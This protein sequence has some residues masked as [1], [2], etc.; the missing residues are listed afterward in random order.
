M[1]AGAGED[2]VGLVD[3]FIEGRSGRGS[4]ACG[5][6][7]ECGHVELALPIYEAQVDLDFGRGGRNTDD[8]DAVDVDDSLALDVQVAHEVRRQ[9]GSLV[10][11]GVAEVDDLRQELPRLHVGAQLGA[12]VQ[13]LIDGV[14]VAFDPGLAEL[15]RPFGDDGGDE[16]AEGFV[17][18]GVIVGGVGRSDGIEVIFV[19]ETGAIERI[20]EVERYI[21]ADLSDE[22]GGLL[23]RLER[24]EDAGGVVDEVDDHWRGLLGGAVV[25]A[26]EP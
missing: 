19:V 1:N 14:G 25:D 17:I 11:R 24:V 15:R 13:Q 10:Q 16:R 7:G 2:V 20:G 22:F 26:I 3:C 12:E 4:L 23:I 21:G 5:C 6:T 9:D 8:V 18:D